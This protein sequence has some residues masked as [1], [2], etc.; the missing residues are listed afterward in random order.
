M[1]TFKEGLEDVVVA[2]S[3]IC[4]I[5]GERGILSYRGIDIHEL[6][7]KSSFEEV[8]FLLWEGRL[9]RLDELEE[10]RASIARERAIPRE[11]LSLL[12]TLA[13]TSI[14]MDARR[15]TDSAP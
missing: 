11:L 1:S 12:A 2:T 5:D 3:S 8:C 6:A 13:R 14:S 9:P 4:F 10:T 7:Q 15:S